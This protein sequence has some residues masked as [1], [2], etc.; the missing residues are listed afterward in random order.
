MASV[1]TY[2]SQKSIE[3]ITYAMQCYREGGVPRPQGCDIFTKSA[4]PYTSDTNASCP[5]AKE[6]CQSSTGNLLLDSGDLDSFDHLGFNTGP[7][8][9]LR[10]Q[11][12]CAPLNT[13]NFTEIHTDTQDSS[14][15]FMRY[16]YG[17]KANRTFLFQAELDREKPRSDN[18]AIGNYKV[19]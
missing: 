16:K 13:L 12:H 9:L 2:Q 5:F 14:K 6:M 10:H 15:R 17:S 8:F 19:M 3:F 4:L 18:V 1:M 7:R 11:T